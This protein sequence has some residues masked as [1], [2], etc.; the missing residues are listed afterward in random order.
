MEDERAAQLRRRN[1]QEFDEGRWEHMSDEELVGAV[2]R[3]S[4]QTAAPVEMSRRLVNELRAFNRAA[5]RWRT[6]L[7][8]LTEALIVLTFVLVILAAVLL[9]H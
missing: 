5:D 7:E 2:A 3:R 9:T 8:R 6:R 4:D 1:K